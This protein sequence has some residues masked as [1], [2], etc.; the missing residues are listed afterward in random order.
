MTEG[1]HPKPR[2]GFPSALALGVNGLDEVVE[3]ELAERMPVAELF[4]RLCD[5][6]QPGLAIKSVMLLPEGF[7]KAQLSRADYIITVPDTVDVDAA[8]LAIKQ[9]K[10]KDSVSFERKNKTV[11]VD[12]SQIPKIEIHGDELRLSLAASQSASLRP[13]DVLDLIDASDWIEKGSVI[14]RTRVVLQKEFES[15]DPAIIATALP[16]QCPSEPTS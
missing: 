8:Q 7:G 16:G 1:F 12:T 10:A 4:Q 9:L 2:V 3:L 13:G 14:S 11:T 6:N 5:D 15:S